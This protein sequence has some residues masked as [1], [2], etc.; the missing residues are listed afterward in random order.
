VVFTDNG[1]PVAACG[2]S[3]GVTLNGAG[4]ATCTVTYPSAGTHS[5][6][7]RY[8]GTTYLNPSASPTL[9]EVIRT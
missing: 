7:A 4:V 3:G 2:G 6:V 8:P 9:A 1:S 5:I